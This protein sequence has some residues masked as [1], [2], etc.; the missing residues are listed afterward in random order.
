MSQ[1]REAGPSPGSLP[2]PPPR[3]TARPWLPCLL[4]AALAVTAH[5]PVLGNGFVWD[6]LYHILMDPTIRSPVN[7]PAAFTQSLWS[8]L[9]EPVMTDYYRPLLILNF[10]LDYSLWGLRPAGYHAVSLL[11]HAACAVLFLLLAARMG[12]GRTASL[13]AA[14]VFAVHPA[15]TE[16]VAFA[17]DRNDLLVT[18][19]LMAAALAALRSRGPSR[20]A[21]RLPV[22]WPA[23]LFFN[24]ALYSKEIA[25]AFLPLIAAAPLVRP[26][27]GGGAREARRRAAGLA[28]ALTLSAVPYWLAREAVLGA[29]VGV[30]AVF[31]PDLYWTPRLLLKYFAT[32][33]QPLPLNASHH[34]VHGGPVLSPSQALAAA[35]GGGLILLVLASSRRR[36]PILFSLAWF[37]LTILPAC[38]VLRGD[39]NFAERYLY[40]SSTGLLLATAFALS[41]VRGRLG[42]RSGA[43]TAVLLAALVTAMAM[44]SFRRDLVWRDG[45][46]LWADTYR[47]SPHRFLAANNYLSHYAPATEGAA[48]LAFLDGFFRR[49]EADGIK[50]AAPADF[51]SLDAGREI[52]EA[53]KVYR[54][55]ITLLHLAGRN[56]EAGRFLARLAKLDPYSPETAFFSGLEA[57]R[58]G[59][60]EEAAREFGICLAAKASDREARFNRALALEEAGRLREAREDFAR[61]REMDPGDA[62]AGAA[63]ERLERRLSAAP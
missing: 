58:R 60:Y 21:G 54:A 7:I 34:L 16:T 5:L 36:G 38:R 3:V 59:L 1:E 18:A 37:L 25:I 14:A 32:F 42:A 27:E 28:A 41:A 43:A 35:A 6:D 4:V 17:S 13:W 23:V 45:R 12:L 40:L 56:E 2:A 15:R 9:G 44:V 24:L 11:L 48:A 61:L 31:G 57:M 51:R 19:F 62:E 52:Q 10:M 63:L 46:T 47:R 49:L 29:S 26:S 20:P 55:Y 8:F 39:L 50:A 30:R 33:F 53:I 22:C